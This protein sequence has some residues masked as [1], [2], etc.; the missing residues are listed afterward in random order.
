M[1]N[2]LDLVHNLCKAIKKCKN[3]SFHQPEFKVNEIEIIA[4]LSDQQN[5]VKAEDVSIIFQ[6]ITDN[7]STVLGMNPKIARPEWMILTVLPV[8]P[9][10]LRLKI[11]D[12][13]CNSK[14]QDNE[15]N[16]IILVNN[17]HFKLLNKKNPNEEELAD[18]LKLLQKHVTIFID[19]E[20]KRVSGVNKPRLNTVA[21]QSHFRKHSICKNLL[22]KYVNFCGR[23]IIT[24]D[25]NLQIDEIGIPRSMA[26]KLTFPEI[27][28]PLNIVEMRKFANT[29]LQLG[30]FV[31][32]QLKDGDIVV[33]NQQPSWK[34]VNM[35]SYKVKILPSST[36]RLNVS[37]VTLCNANFD[38]DE[39]TLH[40]PQSIETCAEV[41]SIQNVTK[42]IISPSTSKPDM[43]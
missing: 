15:L 41:N 4:V 39:A 24:P 33:L 6:K 37:C 27:V 8:S 19:N 13:H 38:G 21:N 11:Q 28:T 16:N 10:V 32:R 7:D 1:Q 23:T 34:R 31:E 35:M 18:N 25:P 20:I 29:E 40:V 14:G 42:Q 3:C 17:I 26:K 36:F 22:S 12:L 43:S 5:N 2:R 30:H 9:P